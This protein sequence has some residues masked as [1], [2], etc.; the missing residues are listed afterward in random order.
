MT[1]ALQPAESRLPRLKLV[2]KQHQSQTWQKDLDFM[3]NE[4]QFFR[5][6]LKAGLLNGAD[7]NKPELY[8]LL[9][10]FSELQ[11]NMLPELWKSLGV[12]DDEEGSEAELSFVKK[13]GQCES[14]LKKLKSDVFPHILEFQSFII[15]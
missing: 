14:T 5:R 9:D 13:L 11:D 12:V 15:W 8:A 1:V 6:L 2:R 3:E 4:V 10:D 7:R